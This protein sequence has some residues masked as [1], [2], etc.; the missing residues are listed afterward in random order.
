MG[1]PPRRGVRAPQRFQY[2]LRRA[3]SPRARPY[4]VN[5]GWSRS[6]GRAP[7]GAVIVI[8]GLLWL[9]GLGL[10]KAAWTPE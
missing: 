4:V 6:W 7:Q 1:I 8:A 10:S 3:S 9:A 5:I 2:L